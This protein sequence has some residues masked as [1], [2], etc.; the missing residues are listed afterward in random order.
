MVSS[1]PVTNAKS[2][3]E[4]TLKGHTI[5]LKFDEQDISGQVI[6]HFKKGE[7]IVAHEIFE[8]HRWQTVG[9]DSIKVYSVDNESCSG[10]N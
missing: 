8:R 3:K 7:G 6:F 4:K 10:K 1:N 9:T 2:R 5:L